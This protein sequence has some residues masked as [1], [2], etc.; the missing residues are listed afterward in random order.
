M[1][2]RP[3]GRDSKFPPAPLRSGPELRGGGHLAA[4]LR[5]YGGFRVVAGFGQALVE[6][7]AGR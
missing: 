2:R 3:E 5:I 4:G 7:D 1:G 6:G